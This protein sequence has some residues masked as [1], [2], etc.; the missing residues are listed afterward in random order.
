MRCLIDTNILILDLK[1]ANSPAALRLSSVPL[2]QQ[3][4]C[5]VVEAELFHGAQKY[6]ATDRRETILRGF[7]A[8][9]HSFAFDSV[10][11]RH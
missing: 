9:Y 7:L 2:S 1:R 6:D 11:A 10:F 5:S 8:P 4:I 3:C